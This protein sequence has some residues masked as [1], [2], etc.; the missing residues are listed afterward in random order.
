MAGRKLFT[1]RSNYQLAVTLQVRASADP[2]DTAGAREFA[3]APGESRWEEYGNEID[4]YLNGLDLSAVSAGALIAQQHVVVTRGSPLDDQL[5]TRNAVD[6]DCNGQAFT[7]S[8][9]QAY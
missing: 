8:T 2:G 3:L 1:N 5:N 9:R 6:I 7:L 4:I